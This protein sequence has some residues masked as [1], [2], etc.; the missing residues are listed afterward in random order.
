MK[1]N[2]TE[3][4][5]NC[6]RWL[7]QEV[8][9]GKLNESFSLSDS[10]L[11]GV[12]GV[13][14]AGGVNEDQLRQQLDRGNVEA[15][16]QANLLHVSTRKETAG[17]LTVH[18][19]DFV[20]TGLAFQAV[21]LDF[22][23]ESGHSLASQN[24]AFE[25]V[26]K[27]VGNVEEDV[28]Q[29]VRSVEQATLASLTSTG[30]SP[31]A[32]WAHRV[33]NAISSLIESREAKVIGAY[34][35]AIS[36]APAHTFD[37]VTPQH[38]ANAVMDDLGRYYNHGSLK[39]RHVA[40]MAG[41]MDGLPPSLQ[42]HE[43]KTRNRVTGEIEILLGQL[44]TMQQTNEAA[45]QKSH[46]IPTMEFAPATTPRDGNNLYG[47][48]RFQDAILAVRHMREHAINV[49]INDDWF[50]TSL[51]AVITETEFL[52]MSTTVALARKIHE[53]LG[54]FRRDGQLTHLLEDVE[55]RMRDEAQQPC[56]GFIYVPRE[57]LRFWDPK[58]E[59]GSE[60]FE[61]FCGV[62]FEITEA[63]R[64]ITANRPTACVLHLMRALE[65]PISSLCHELG[66]QGYQSG[67]GPAVEAI[68]SRIKEWD[69]PNTPGRPADWNQ[70]RAYFSEAAL[71]ISR[72]RIAWRN[73]AMHGTE[74]YDESEAIKI[75]GHTKDF[76]QRLAHLG[77]TVP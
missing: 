18:F 11:P 28:M 1:F 74:T 22:A 6:L 23:D 24:A 60:V 25:L 8:H 10:N 59:F 44:R 40:K 50:K 52:G 46:Q 15:L 20:L 39:I 4:Q 3:R 37:Q 36:A 45:A 13:I 5:K 9:A 34:T 53:H 76:M 62:E 63:G 72:I 48:A 17:T 68:E 70:R 58:K 38:L 32:S 43:S 7:V 12:S 65:K 29:E 30:Q 64:C 31:S 55:G 35:K 21:S 49:S 57:K 73:Y 27:L 42:E 71:D 2:L 26:Q 67:W 66:V 61:R 51:H 47:P 75:W 41:Y 19:R 54:K 16:R 56:F 77:A 33:S 69:K 14:G